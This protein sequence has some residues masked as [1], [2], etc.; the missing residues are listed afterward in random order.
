MKRNN[1]WNKIIHCKENNHVGNFGSNVK[2]VLLKSRVSVDKTAQQAK[3][4]KHK[5]EEKATKSSSQNG[6]SSNSNARENHTNL[7]TFYKL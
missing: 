1:I 4:V 5:T 7:W 6:R 3:K 2:N